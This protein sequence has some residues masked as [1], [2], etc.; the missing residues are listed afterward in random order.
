M[1]GMKERMM[2]MDELIAEAF[3]VGAQTEADVIAYVNTFM[4]ADE[5]YIAEQMELM[6][7]PMDC[8]L[9]VALDSATYLC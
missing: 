3:E 7:G 8:G 5:K 9:Q 6:F 1:G 2:D 4:V